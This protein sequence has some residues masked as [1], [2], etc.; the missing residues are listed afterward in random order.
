LRDFP[1]IP[2]EPARINRGTTNKRYLIMKSNSVEIFRCNAVFSQNLRKMA[3]ELGMDKS[4]LIRFA[5]I[6]TLRLI[7]SDQIKVVVS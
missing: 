6:H 4:S 1:V 3:E 7:K 2:S 5:L